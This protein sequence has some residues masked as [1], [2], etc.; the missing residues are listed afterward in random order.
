MDARNSDYVI[1]SE[2]YTCFA[3][4]KVDHQ[5]WLSSCVKI[6][7]FGHFCP[8]EV[9]NLPSARQLIRHKTLHFLFSTLYFKISTLQNPKLC[10]PQY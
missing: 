7:T 5:K 3:L 8:L 1:L 9:F 10:P 2:N 4:K 6:T